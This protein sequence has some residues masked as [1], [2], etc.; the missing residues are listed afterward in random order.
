[1]INWINTPS[2]NLLL[3]ILVGCLFVLIAVVLFF[4]YQDNN[5]SISET[6]MDAR[7]KLRAIEDLET[8]GNSQESLREYNELLNDYGDPYSLYYVKLSRAR[9]LLSTGDMT[10]AVMALKELEALYSS[11]EIGD[12][13]RA[14]IINV[15]LDSYFTQ[16]SGELFSEI[17]K[18]SP[19]SQFSSVSRENAIFEIIKLSDSLADTSTGKLRLAIYYANEIFGGGLIDSVK[20]DYSDQIISLVNE[21]EL[22]FWKEQSS[23]IPTK[24]TQAQRMLFTYRQGYALAAVSLVDKSFIKYYEKKFD[25]VLK[26]AADN[27]DNVIMQQLVPYAN[28]YYASFILLN[29]ETGEYLD[30]QKTAALV[31]RTIETGQEPITGSPF[32]RFITS[33][34]SRKEAER[35]HNYYLIDKLRTAYPQFLA[36]TNQVLHP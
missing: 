8:E 26:M 5:N 4:Q 32:R 15:V 1:M 16:Q 11:Q 24:L 9:V 3:G 35:N 25:E 30:D 14:W 13:S 31:S 6:I 27:P 18:V 20:Q 7:E 10:N 33:E 21:S 22:L 34:L 36:Y 29:K 23:A 28:F 2:K 19:F 17:M 12:V